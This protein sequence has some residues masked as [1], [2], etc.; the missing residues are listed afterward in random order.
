MMS[1][2]CFETGWTEDYA[3][4]LDI[5]K[6]YDILYRDFEYFPESQEDIEKEIEAKELSIKEGLR[7]LRKE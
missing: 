2:L 3:Y 5:I 1:G 6:I 7:R 4:E